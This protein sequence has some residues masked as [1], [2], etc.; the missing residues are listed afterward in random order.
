MESSFQKVN[1][2]ENDSLKQ[3]LYGIAMWLFNNEMDTIKMQREQITTQY[4]DNPYFLLESYPTHKDLA[5]NYIH[6]KILYYFSKSGSDYTIAVKDATDYLFDYPF[7]SNVI[8][9]E[10]IFDNLK[11]YP[12]VPEDI[13]NDEKSSDIKITELG[14]MTSPKRFEISYPTENKK[15]LP[16][17]VKALVQTEIPSTIN[18]F[19]FLKTD[20]GKTQTKNN[21]SVTLLRMANNYAEIEVNIPDGFFKDDD[22]CKQYDW[23]KIEAKDQTAQYLSMA[24]AT[25]SLSK[26]T[27]DTAAGNLFKELVAQEKYTPEFVSAFIEKANKV[28]EDKRA[29]NET[30]DNNKQYRFQNFR[31]IVNEINVDIF[32]Y[33]KSEMISKEVVYPI[34][35]FR[36]LISQGDFKEIQT[37]ASV[38]DNEIIALANKPY[39][40][41]ED[42]LKNQITTDQV[43]TIMLKSSVVNF[44]YPILVSS[45]IIE[46]NRYNKIKEV[47]FLNKNERPID[48]SPDSINYGSWEKRGSMINV[49]QKS[50]EY[51]QNRFLE[52]PYYV[53]GV[54]ELNLV[55]VKKQTYGI[56]NL[57]EGVLIKGN[58]IL[59]DQKT[60]NSGKYALFVKDNTNRY[61]KT[62]YEYSC[63][64]DI[65]GVKHN[66]HISYYYGTPQ[67]IEIYTKAGTK[68]VDY[69]FKVK[70]T[71]EENGKYINMW[72]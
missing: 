11:S 42:D 3:E 31:G 49:N 13:K 43:P 41:E 4:K 61:L 24:S 39:E 44:N 69:N 36:N 37:T 66:K 6:Q 62:I 56:S 72:N 50:I 32:D 48:I 64:I 68:I 20:I 19:H 70:L 38:Y 52:T 9:Q 63:A 27:Y 40:I 53:T 29:L 65:D 26:K 60:F 35:D 57:P 10:V 45:K 12:I 55:D 22:I 25:S 17:K 28:I 46:D 8:W 7:K 54:L 51:F 23:I 59:L 5:E 21:V 34:S 15:P 2:I 18:Q 67:T 71:S 16:T 1:A 47:S 14:K 58:A 30:R 33:S